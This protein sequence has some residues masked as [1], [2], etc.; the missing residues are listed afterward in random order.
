MALSLRQI[1]TCR[2]SRR[3]WGR[4]LAGLLL[5][6]RI[7]LCQGLK[8]VPEATRAERPVF[9]VGANQQKEGQAKKC[10]RPVSRPAHPVRLAEYRQN[11]HS[12]DTESSPVVIEFT[13]FDIGGT[14]FAIYGPGHIACRRSKPL[15]LLRVEGGVTGESEASGGVD[16]CGRLLLGRQYAPAV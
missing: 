16:R 7:S 12:R 15:R 1:W 8:A 5:I 4:C 9:R 6:S 2:V 13:P 11:A 10:Q 14:A 3:Q